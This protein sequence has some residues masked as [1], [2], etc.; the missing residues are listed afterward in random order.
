MSLGVGWMNRM[1]RAGKRVYTLTLYLQDPMDI[2]VGALG[3]IE[4]CKGYYC[5]TGS[6]QGGVGRIFRHLKRIGQKNDNPRWHIDYLL[7]FTTFSSLMVSYFPK[8]YECLIA[9][10]L[11]EVL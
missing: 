8:E 2:R 4:F 9:S 5:Y 11:G 7:P 3:R 6:A 1:N 10:R